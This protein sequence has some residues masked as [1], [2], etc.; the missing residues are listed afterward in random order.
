[1]NLNIEALMVMSI[2]IHLSSSKDLAHLNGFPVT[3]LHRVLH[4]ITGIE[5]WK[6]GERVDPGAAR[7]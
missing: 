1:M 6:G 3:P 4:L 2:S 5:T 7:A